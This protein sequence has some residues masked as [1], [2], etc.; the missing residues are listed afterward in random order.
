MALRQLVN[1]SIRCMITY[2]R[3]AWWT[4]QNAQTASSENCISANSEHFSERL[5]TESVRVLNRENLKYNIQL[6]NVPSRSPPK[7]HYGSSW[8]WAHDVWLHTVGLHC[9]VTRVH[10]LWA[11][12]TTYIYRLNLQTYTVSPF[13]DSSMQLREGFWD[14]TSVYQSVQTQKSEQRIM[15]IVRQKFSTVQE[16]ECA[17]KHRGTKVAAMDSC[18]AHI[19]ARQHCIAKHYGDTK[20]FHSALYF[21]GGPTDVGLIKPRPPHNKCGT[22]DCGVCKT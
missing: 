9:G 5:S 8:T 13:E 7:W 2:C 15:Q 4:H 10:K 19:K 14:W 6:N 3:I 12:S 22:F 21:Q 18:F 17:T 1:S 11:L 16:S 20:S